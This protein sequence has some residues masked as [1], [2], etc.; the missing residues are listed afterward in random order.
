MG[1]TASRSGSDHT[2]VCGFE[3]H[4]HLGQTLRGFEAA[5]RSG[6]DFTWFLNSKQIWVRPNIYGFETAS[7]SGSDHIYMDSEQQ[8][9]LGQTI[10]G[11]EPADTSGCDNKWV[12]NSKQVWVRPYTGSM[13]H[14]SDCLAR[15]QQGIGLLPGLKVKLLSFAV[16][17]MQDLGCVAKCCAV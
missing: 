3:Q 16:H 13:Q 15:I 7:R 17:C 6:S 1:G 11:F 8:A 5:S 4:T 12:R 2:Y 10:C 9:D 14:N